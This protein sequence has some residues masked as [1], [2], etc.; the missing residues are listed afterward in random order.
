MI[1]RTRRRGFTLVELL[2]VIAIIGVLIALL[3]PAIQAA[4]EAARRSAC[5]NN[6]KQIGLGLHNH[7]DAKGFFPPSALS[8]ALYNN[9][10][11]KSSAALTGHL[12]GWSFLAAILPFMDYDPVYQQLPFNAGDPWSI[13]NPFSW[14]T[15]WPHGRNPAVRGYSGDAVFTVCDMSLP[16]H[17]CPSSPFGHLANPDGTLCNPLGQGNSREGTYFGT[18]N[19]KCMVAS[20]LCS[21]EQAYRSATG[22]TQLKDAYIAPASNGSWHADGA[23]PTNLGTKLSY[24]TDGTAHTIMANESI[25]N[26]YFSSWLIPQGT[27]AV[28]FPDQ[29]TTGNIAALKKYNM[30][31]AGYPNDGAAAGYKRSAT[32]APLQFC[33]PEGYMPGFYGVTNSSAIVDANGA[34]TGGLYSD[35]VPYIAVDWSKAPWQHNY[36]RT[37][38]G[39]GVQSQLWQ[40]G[41]DWYNGTD[42]FPNGLSASHAVGDLTQAVGAEYGPSAGHPTVNN[43]LMVDGG[44]KSI[45]KEIDVSVYYFMI[46]AH[47][48]D[49]YL[50]ETY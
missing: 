7:C 8:A 28:G 36:L 3:L 48:N 15:D 32:T 21:A 39:S 41:F 23:M 46:T 1:T 37:S 4:R 10:Q 16:E 49:P 5:T 33:A 43:H 31:I 38:G 44:V 14:M 22:S 12:R 17:C 40:P 47:G 9:T 2:V 27:L 13:M 45:S 30:W 26:T 20:T 25:D 18:T 24:Y 11:L 34:P 19:Y 42:D 50:Y 6:L 35:L 29:W